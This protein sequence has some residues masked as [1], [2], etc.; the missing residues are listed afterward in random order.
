MVQVTD[1]LSLTIMIVESAGRPAIYR[2]RTLTTLNNDQG[3]CWADGEGPFSL[4]GCNSDGSLQCLGPILTPRPMNAT[5]E[6]EAY[7]FHIG[8]CHFLFG[9]GHVAF[10]NEN[11]PLPTFAALCT[12][13]GEEAV[14]GDF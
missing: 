13:S 8:G 3:I 4:D 1:G 14:T 10:L 9:D 6:N 7:S 12:R 2:G 11:M 5:N